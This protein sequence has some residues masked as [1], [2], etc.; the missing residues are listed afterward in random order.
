MCLQYGRL[1]LHLVN[2][3]PNLLYSGTKILG[4]SDFY[5]SISLVLAFQLRSCWTSEQEYAAVHLFG[6][7]HC[8]SPAMTLLGK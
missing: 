7:R 8:S 4:L 5:V 2:V 3:T 1:R 6:A